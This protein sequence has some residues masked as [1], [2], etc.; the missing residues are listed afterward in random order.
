MHP[1]LAI[2]VLSLAPAA[3]AEHVGLVA[4]IGAGA[5][6][7]DVGQL[8]DLSSA[9]VARLIHDA[10]L[11]AA[12]LVQVSDYVYGDRGLPCRAVPGDGALPL[13]TLLG[14]I[15]RSGFTGIYDLEI[16]GPR[17]AAEGVENG[18]IR[19]AKH[20]GNILDEQNG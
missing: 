6:T 18:L 19:A 13:D 12:A 17:L 10:G 2:N 7:P 4:R 11:K 14:G 9:Q 1:Q 8:D 3:F 5:I 15:I 20:V 16:I